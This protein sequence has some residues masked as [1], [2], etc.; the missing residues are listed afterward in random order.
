MSV[1]EIIKT[2]HYYWHILALSKWGSWNDSFQLLSLENGVRTDMFP[3]NILIFTKQYS[4]ATKALRGKQL[5]PEMPSPGFSPSTSTSWGVSAKLTARVKGLEAEGHWLDVP[6]VLQSTVQVYS[7]SFC[8]QNS[9]AAWKPWVACV[10]TIVV[11][12]SRLTSVVITHQCYS[13]HQLWHQQE[14]QECVSM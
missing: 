14:L 6:S 2:F 13:Q 5:Y 1:L 11:F 7:V 10:N 3:Q 4:L 8:L 9:T 12:S